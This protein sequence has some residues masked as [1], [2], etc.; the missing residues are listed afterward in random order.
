[1]VPGLAPAAKQGGRYVAD[2]IR[3]VAFGKQKP[4]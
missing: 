3:A 4:M 1:M 2:V